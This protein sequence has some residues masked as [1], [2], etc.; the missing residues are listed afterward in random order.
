LVREE[1]AM[2]IMFSV[3][4]GLALGA[5]LSNQT[6]TAVDWR[7][8]TGPGGPFLVTMISSED[9]TFDG[10]TALTITVKNTTTEPDTISQVQIGLYFFSADGKP[11][12]FR[13]FGQDVTLPP[14]SVVTFTKELAASGGKR[15]LKPQGTVLVVPTAATVGARIWQIDPNSFAR[16]RP[17]DPSVPIE[18]HFTAPRPRGE[19]TEVQCAG[20]DW[21]LSNAR[22]ACGYRVDGQ[23]QCLG[24]PCI[25]SFSCTC[26]PDGGYDCN[27]ECDENCC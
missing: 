3:I 16:L 4:L 8:T 15:L 21:C 2:A 13:S 25:H 11:V 17:R 7:L 6:E 24:S 26:R 1:N 22:F 18:G 14:G 12:G 5:G 23:G 19:G 20:C 9:V 10:S 27:F